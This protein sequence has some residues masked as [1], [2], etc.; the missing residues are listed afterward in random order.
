MAAVKKV[1][2]PAIPVYEEPSEEVKRKQAVFRALRKIF[3][4]EEEEEALDLANEALRLADDGEDVDT[5]LLQYMQGRYGAEMI[6]GVIDQ[7]RRCP[8][9]RELAYHEPAPDGFAGRID[10][11]RIGANTEGMPY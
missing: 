11:S 9:F 7:L 4:W 8:E 5:G 3:D 2:M 1:A 10:W 6:A